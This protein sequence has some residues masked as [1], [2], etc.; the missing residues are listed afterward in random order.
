MIHLSLIFPVLFITSLCFGQWE[1]V[2]P[3][4]EAEKSPAVE[5]LRSDNAGFTARLTLNG[6]FIETVD[7]DYGA[8]HRLKLWEPFEA[9]TK[10]T[11][12]PQ[13]P[14]LVKLFEVPSTAVVSIEAQTGD[15]VE[16]AGYRPYPRQQPL[17][18]G[19]APKPFAFNPAAYN[20]SE[21]TPETVARV[22]E[23]GVWRHIQVAKLELF[24]LQYYPAKGLLRI[25]R[26]ITI[27]ISFQPGETPPFELPAVK[28]IPPVYMRMYE[29]LVINYDHS[30]HRYGT[31]E[32]PVGTKYL[33]IAPEDALNPLQPLADLRNAQGFKTE[34]RTISPDFQTPNQFKHYIRQLYLQSGLE[35]VLM[36][37]DPNVN[38]PMVPMYYWDYDPPEAS[39]SDSWY[40]CVI[41]GG[42][43]DHHPELAIGRFIYTRRTDLERQVNKTIG[44]LTDYDTAEDWFEKSLLVAHREDYPFKYTECKEQIR[45]YN[46]AVQTPVFT[47]IYGGAGG[48]NSDIINYINGGSCGLFNYRGHGTVTLWP[49]WGS[50]SFSASHVNQMN[51]QCRL[52]ILFDVCCLNGNAVTGSS[53]CLAESFMLANNAAAAV[54]AA[55]RPSYTDPNHVYDRE[56]YRNIYHYGVSCI[57][58]ASNAAS[59]AV[60]SLFGSIGEANF[61][62][63]YWQ[64]DPAIDI[65]THTPD[66]VEVIAPLR[67]SFGQESA[68]FTIRAGGI[69]VPEAMVCLRNNEIYAFGYTDSL[70]TAALSFNPLPL[71][72]GQAFLTVSGHNLAFYHDTLEVGG[73]LG[74]LQGT[75]SGGQSNLPLP[76]AEVIIAQSGRVTLTDSAGFYHFD[77]LPAFT[78]DISAEFD[79]YIAQTAENIRVDSGRVTALDFALLHSQCAPN[80]SQITSRIPMGGSEQ[81]PF[82]IHNGGDGALEYEMDITGPNAGP[83]LQERLNIRV[84]YWTGDSA[85][86][87]VAFDGETFWIAGEGTAASNNLYKFD[88][89]GNIVGMMPQPGALTAEGFSDICWDGDYLYGVEGAEIYRFDTSGVLSRNIPGSFNPIKSITYDPDSRRF[90]CAGGNEAI[91]EIDSAG[92]VLNIL[93]HGLDITGLGWRADD[94]EG[95]PLYVFSRDPQLTISRINPRSGEISRVG[96]IMTIPGGAA[97]GCCVSGDVDPFHILLLGIVDSDSED[98]LLGWQLGGSFFYVSVAPDSGVIISG[99]TEQFIVTLDGARLPENTYNAIIAIHHNALGGLT[100]IPV[101]LTVY[102]AGVVSQ[103]NGSRLSGEFRLA[104]PRPNP[105]NPRTAVEF[106]LQV[107]VQVKI[108]VF[109][110]MGRE[111][112]EVSLGMMEAGNHNYIFNGEGLASGIYIIRLEAGDFRAAAKTVL[113]K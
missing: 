92:T 102:G 68:D 81:V 8:F 104:S 49:A 44:Y 33:I 78:Y 99:G 57:S 39:Y 2:S 75:V 16:L 5:L 71:Q 105:F 87:G 45:T 40:T 96:D 41:P 32:D 77:Q 64:G 52:F 66:T 59:V 15:Y 89:Q 29:A 69:P 84:E 35:Y 70:G 43:D 63:Y 47:T 37:G 101:Q 100:E 26:T 34:I 42:D 86:H 56:F 76:G 51:N 21:Y 24:P 9:A 95:M 108:T 73:G 88:R 25:H 53:V 109:D 7:T 111:V 65:W 83:S 85:L 11:G 27:H 60:T 90:F 74:T 106:S 18:E 48:S 14:A 36:A 93:Y 30:R 79:G 98:R 61:R 54:H 4:N 1:W 50:G 58:Y 17:K 107:K 23:T 19:E 20:L 72:P 80:V 38:N 103:E 94:P 112:E 6:L 67:I 97:A 3:W 46:Y 31:D 110:V 10:E 13:L 82:S 55:I 28:N 91:R 113:L 22:G 12:C 62:M